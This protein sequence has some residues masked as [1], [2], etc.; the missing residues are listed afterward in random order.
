METEQNAE[1]PHKI[2][3]AKRIAD[4][5]GIMD[6]AEVWWNP[7]GKAKEYVKPEWKG[8]ILF[9]GLINEKERNFIFVRPANPDEI[10]EEL[11]NMPESSQ[12]RKGGTFSAERS[13]GRETR[14]VRQACLKAACAA[15]HVDLNMEREPQGKGL[16][17][18]AEQFYD[19]V[20]S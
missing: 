1:K 6:E 17:A 13:N 15:A 19:W 2:I 12:E 16:I 10:P 9:L 8:K 4:N 11:A 5:G 7:L 20:M 3:R 18:L 14:I